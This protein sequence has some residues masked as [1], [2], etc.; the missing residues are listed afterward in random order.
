MNLVYTC[1]PAAARGAASARRSKAKPRAAARLR[2]PTVDIHC[3]VFTPE[4]A[5]LVKDVVRPQNDSYSFFQSAA[6]KQTDLKQAAAIGPKL[7]S[8]EE[9]LKTMDA[10]GIDIQA[11]STAPIQYYYWADGTLALR[12]SRLIN[13]NIAHICAANPERFVGL[14]TVPMQV[15]EYAVREL[16]RAVKELGLKGVEICPHVEQEELSAERF[17]PFFAKAE[18]LGAVIFMHPHG[19]PD[20][21]RLADHFFQN[22]VGN[23]LDTTV[24]IHHLIF[25]GVLEAH[26]KLKIVCAH[27]GGYLPAYAGRIDHAHAARPDART[28]ITKAPSSYLKKLYF[29]TI[30]FT[31]HQLAYLVDQYGADHILLGTDYPY[32]MALPDAVQFVQKAPGLS[33]RERGLILGG[34][35]ARLLGIALPPAAPGR[36]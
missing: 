9:R 8:I 29:D 24:A 18:E 1:A 21:R 17:R 22:I 14:A 19:F 15:P 23:P 10:E 4:A 32:D 33:E 35:A 36:R 7:T 26:P 12:T 2:Q 25:G 6:S 5:A 3:H 13:D 20:G 34:N 11:I 16:T 28:K 31:H 30:V 27:G